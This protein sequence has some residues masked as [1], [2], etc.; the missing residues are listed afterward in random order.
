[1]RD[2]YLPAIA[3]MAMVASV[4]ATEIPA[5][6]PSKDLINSTI[7]MTVLL[8]HECNCAKYYK[9]SDGE[10]VLKQCD[11]DEK[12]DDNQR[13][14][15]PEEKAVCSTVPLLSTATTPP[16]INCPPGNDITHI[17]H[18]TDCELYYTCENG[19]KQLKE[20]KNGLH[21]DEIKGVCTLSE[22]VNCGSRAS[23]TI[24]PLLPD[25]GNT[26]DIS[27]ADCPPDGSHE[28]RTLPHHCLCDRYYICVNGELILQMCKNGT[29]YDYIREVCDDPKHFNCIRPIPT[30]TTTPA[31]TTTTPTPTTTTPAPTT[32][33]P[34]PTTTTPAPTTTTPAPTTT[35]PAPTTTTPA[36]TTTTP[37]PTTTTPAPTTT[38]PAPTTTT[39]AP[40]TTTPAP[41]TTTTTTPEP[42]K[43]NGICMIRDPDPKDCAWY[44]ECTNGHKEH[45][46]CHEGLQFNPSTRMC[47]L[48]QYVKCKVCTDTNDAETYCSC[49]DTT[50][51][52]LPHE[53]QCNKYYICENGNANVKSCPRGY[54]YDRVKHHCELA[55]TVV[56]DKSPNNEPQNALGC[57]GTCPV[58]NSERRT[59]VTYLPHIECTNFCY[60]DKGTPVAY[61][62]SKGFHFSRRDQNC[63]D[64]AIAQCASSFTYG[65]EDQESTNAKETSFWSHIHSTYR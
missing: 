1:M 46:K 51:D 15:V 25:T 58:H 57:I 32:T 13:K 11:S 30:P 23:R 10:L 36:P 33:T 22:D 43:C 24:A 19:R 28:N 60:C 65:D 55:D 2:F 14:C 37:A 50:G 44:Y 29:Q 63:T 41:T 26:Y 20:C 40:T 17:P 3:M 4:L 45:M 16:A 31:P 52:R 64:P 35:T 6:C 5:A 12:F 56:C 61:E 54:A 42:E 53:C 39:P 7:H 8:P 21:F 34:A 59:P 62:C 18:E 38:T 47:D 48:P 27:M 49:P 9:C